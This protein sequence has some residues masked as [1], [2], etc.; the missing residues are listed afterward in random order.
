MMLLTS[1]LISNL[2]TT[3]KFALVEAL[4]VAVLMPLEW[5]VVAESL[6]PTTAAITF[7]KYGVID[8]LSEGINQSI[9]N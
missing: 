2:P 7:L 3:A 9:V 1:I 6:D 8:N 5:L 4:P